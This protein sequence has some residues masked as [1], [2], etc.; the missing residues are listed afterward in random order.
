MSEAKPTEQGTERDDDLRIGDHTFRS[1]LLVGTGKYRDVAETKLAL[2]ASGAQIVTVALRRVDL[3]DR[4]AGSM[5][6]LLTGA[7]G[8]EPG[9]MLLPNTAGCYSVEDAVR[10]CRLARELGLSDL[11]KLEVIGDEKTLFPDNGKTI[12]AAEILLA[13]GITVLPYCTDDPIVCKR[14]E[15]IEDPRP[16]QHELRLFGADSR[17]GDAHLVSHLE[18]SV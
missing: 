17:E 13:E 6:G 15:E 1:R 5:M 4:G 18:P 16:V 12:E 14:L 2:E 3:K 11:V 7:D 10:T 8:G 9:F